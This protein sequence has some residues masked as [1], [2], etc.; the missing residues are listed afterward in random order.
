MTTFRVTLNPS[1]HAFD[2]EP[3]KNVL[4]SALDAGIALPYSCRTGNCRTC[5]ATIVAGDVDHAKT[6]LEYLTEDERAAGFALLCQARPRS[7][8]DG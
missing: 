5:R 7:D 8:L 1:G 3:D 6:K 2:A 4:Q